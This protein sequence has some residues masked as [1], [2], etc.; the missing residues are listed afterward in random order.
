M[1]SA[2]LGVPWGNLTPCL[3]VDSDSPWEQADRRGEPSFRLGEAGLS[4]HMVMA[5]VA[6]LRP[7]LPGLAD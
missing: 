7:G 3:V 5:P 1:L 2:G 6:D 4:G